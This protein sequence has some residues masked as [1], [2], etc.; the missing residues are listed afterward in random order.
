MKAPRVAPP[1][2]AFTHGCALRVQVML[3]A[4]WMNGIISRSSAS[5]FTAAPSGRGGGRRVREDT[6]ALCVLGGDYARIGGRRRHIM[7]SCSFQ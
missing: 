2:G 5:L 6:A 7:G 3:I 1:E 4:D